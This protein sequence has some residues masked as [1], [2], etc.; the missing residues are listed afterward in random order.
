MGTNEQL[1]V[2]LRNAARELSSKRSIRDLQQILVHIVEVRIPAS[3]TPAAATGHW[4]TRTPVSR[5]AGFRG[6]LGLAGTISP[7]PDGYHPDMKVA[8]LGATGTAG[9]R[10]VTRLKGRGVDVVE[11]SR[12]TGVL[13]DVRRVHDGD[14]RDVHRAT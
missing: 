1:L 4:S 9:S 2:S 13:R 12:S 5:D 8:V 11:V 7:T 6:T 3:A 14:V 10:T